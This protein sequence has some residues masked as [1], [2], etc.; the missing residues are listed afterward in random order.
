MRMLRRMTTVA[1]FH[2]GDISDILQPT[3]VAAYSQVIQDEPRSP[4]IIDQSMNILTLVIQIYVP[5]PTGIIGSSIQ[6]SEPFGWER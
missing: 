1:T 6:L 4:P 3:P 5:F 2:L